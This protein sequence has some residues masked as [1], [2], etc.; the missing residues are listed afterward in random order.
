MALYRSTSIRRAILVGFWVVALPLISALVIA[1]IAVDRLATQGQR[2]VFAATDTIETSRMLVEDIT[3]ME[4]HAR[5]FQALRDPALHQLFL[6]RHQRFE[7]SARGLL[8][9]ETATPLHARLRELLTEEQALYLQLRGVRAGAPSRTAAFDQFPRLGTQARALLEQS[10]EMVGDVAENMQRAALE[11]Q[12][13]LLWL[14]LLLIVFAS[15]LAALFA[16]LLTRPIKQI[17]E[18]IRHLGDGEFTET[19]AV[20]G[21]DDLVSLG[22]RLEWLRQRLIQLERQKITFLRHISHELKT[23]LAS[24]REG[25]GLLKDRVVGPLNG[26]QAEVTYILH[27]NS[28]QLQRLIE[29]LINFSTT[30]RPAPV[31]ERRRVPLHRLLQA[32]VQDQKLA[33]KAKN[34]SFRL[35]LAEVTIG[36]NAEKLRVVFDNLLSNAIKYTPADGEIS[37]AVRQHGDNVE[38]EVCD[39]GPGIEPDEREKIFEAFHQGRAVAEGHIKG[40]GLGLAIAREYVRLHAGTIEVLDSERGARLRVTLPL[41]SAPAPSPEQATIS[42]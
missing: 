34:I 10:G 41:A 28:L 18:A 33:A 29:D 15:V 30:E 13:L 6:E 1:L 8:E 23:P 12:R 16:V 24:I 42:N 40:S 22:E 39:P 14:A 4:R 3:A 20:S 5:Q 38:I 9:Q 31:I 11:T 35:E 32:L 21:P 27:Q 7:R 25:V 37:L 2:A 19:I 26:E 36:G 17:N